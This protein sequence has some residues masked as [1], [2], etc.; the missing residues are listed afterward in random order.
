MAREP[1]HSLWRAK[2]PS[3]TGKAR[4]QRKHRNHSGIG[5]E[6]SASAPPPT[7]RTPVPTNHD[8]RKRHP[9]FMPG[10][11]FEMKSRVACV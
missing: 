8:W 2:R 6:D 9:V 5:H 7:I 11:Y 10:P 4:G 1:Q 3:R